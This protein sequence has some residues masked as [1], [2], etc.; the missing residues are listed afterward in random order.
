MMDV[1]TWLQQRLDALLPFVQIAVIIAVAIGLQRLAR[2]LIGRAVKRYGLPEELLIGSQRLSGFIIYLI[3]GLA[4]LERLGASM[5]MIWAAFT[6]FAAV[7]AVAFFAAWSVLSNIFC[8]VLIFITRPFRIYD[9][10]EVLEGGDKP[11]LRGRV[12]DINLIYSTLEEMGTGTLLQIPN[13][14]F[15]Q[16]TLRRWRRGTLPP[17]PN[18][19]PSG[20]ENSA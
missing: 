9:Y 15:F 10:I 16:R 3:A 6:G 14:M 19:P 2:Q 8:T 4:C 18:P 1:V 17:P 13:N 20:G 7:A 12:I 5:A 11:G